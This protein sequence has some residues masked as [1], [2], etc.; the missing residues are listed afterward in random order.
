MKTLNCLIVDD[1]PLALDLLETY[2]ARTPFLR[3][4]GRAGS[5]LEAFE[6]LRQ[7][8]ALP[9]GAVDLLFLDI[10]MPQ[11]SGMEFT[12][13]LAERRE[14]FGQPRVVF[15]TA[16]EQYALE[17]FRVDALDYLLK[18]ISYPEF[19]RAAMKAEE[20]FRTRREPLSSSGAL[21]TEETQEVEKSVTAPK[22]DSIWVRADYRQVCITVA[23][24]LYVE[25]VKDYVRICRADG[26]SVMTQ[27]SLKA[28]EEQLP[29]DEFVR[30]H[31]S[32][33]VH[34]AQVKTIERGRILFGKVRIP[35]SDSYREA[36]MER[37]SQRA[38][39]TPKGYPTT[40]E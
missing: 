27:M 23:D 8:A 10:Q 16:F 17:G 18:P 26:S 33:I 29:S 35:I 11:L 1:E 13:L 38:F 28:M 30:V 19:L 2:V 12:R 22:R 25:G 39:I 40:S 31:R 3:L 6:C 9:Q 15:T 24:I 21:P 20:W 34:L 36:F 37:L 32:Y 7:A 5:A 4:A 14:E